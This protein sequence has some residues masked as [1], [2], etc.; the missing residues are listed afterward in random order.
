MWS[1]DRVGHLPADRSHLILDHGGTQEPVSPRQLSCG[2]GMFTLLDADGPDGR[3]LVKLSDRP[4][5]Y[6]DPDRGAPH[7]QRFLDEA[8]SP[9]NRLW[10]QGVQLQVGRVG[11]SSRPVSH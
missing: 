5:Y 8:G 4:G 1:V 6:V 9:A 3:G 10:G 11:V 2:I 7:R